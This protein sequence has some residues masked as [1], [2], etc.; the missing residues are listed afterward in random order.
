MSPSSDNLKN[1]AASIRDRLKI[2]ARA[3]N[4]DFQRLLNNYASLLRYFYFL[5]I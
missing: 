2:I 4:I 1:K 3:D 5:L